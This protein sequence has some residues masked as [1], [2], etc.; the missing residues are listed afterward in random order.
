LILLN[1]L[2]A[3]IFFGL[4]GHDEVMRHQ[5]QSIPLYIMMLYVLFKQNNNLKL[6]KSKRNIYFKNSVYKYLVLIVLFAILF[7]QSLNLNKNNILLSISSC[8]KSG[9][10]N[11]KVI[12]TT[13]NPYL[14][15]ENFQPKS[16]PP[17]NWTPDV[18]SNINW[19]YLYKIYIIPDSSITEFE[20][21]SYQTINFVSNLDLRRNFK[22][23]SICFKQVGEDR[24]IEIGHYYMIVE[25]S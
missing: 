24:A 12:D 2:G 8:L 14:K 9:E 5:V 22:T 11:F 13:I 4:V 20:S 1:W 6:I 17:Y 16:L 10:F 3:A 18:L 21:I 23:N 7:Y 15:K 25:K 19:K